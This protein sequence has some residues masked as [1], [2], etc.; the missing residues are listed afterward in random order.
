[1]GTVVGTCMP[2]IELEQQPGQ[3]ALVPT[4]RRRYGKQKRFSLSL[5]L[6]FAAAALCDA[7]DFGRLPT[8]KS[9]TH[10]HCN[11]YKCAVAKS[12]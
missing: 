8:N 9:Y 12:V 7:C 1:M 10:L 2:D 5:S 3:V 6:P 11:L 4:R